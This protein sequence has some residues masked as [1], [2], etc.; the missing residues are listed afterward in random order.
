[1]SIEGPGDPGRIAS[2]IRSS[3]MTQREIARRM[4]VSDATVSNY[5]LSIR[6]PSAGALGGLA[7]ALGVDVRSLLASAPTGADAE[8]YLAA[9]RSC[10]GESR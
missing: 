4:G 6:K 1:M 3:R 2:A 8:A 5:A 10:D 7:R 9:H